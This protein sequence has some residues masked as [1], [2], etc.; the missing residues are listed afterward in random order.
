[1]ILLSQRD[2]RWKNLKLGTG[3][4]TSTIGAFGC[5][6]T[7]LGMILETTPDVVNDRINSVQGYAN[8]NLVI[9]AKLE[10]AFP[11]LKIKRVWTYDNT[12]VKANV[13]NVLVEVDGKPIGGVRHWVIYIGGGKANDPW[14]GKEKLTSSYPDPLSYCVIGGK[15]NKPSPTA[16]TDTQWTQN[17]DNW[18][19]LL[20]R[21]NFS[22]NKDIVFAELDKLP[23][24]EDANRDKDKQLQVKEQELAEIRQKGSDLEKQLEI[25]SQDLSA[26]IS[27][28]TASQITLKEL[29]VQNDKFKREIEELK[30]TPVSPVLKTW[31]YFKLFVNSFFK[32]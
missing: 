23:L 15:W 11:G 32:I 3:D 30:Q 2:P 22:N 16:T 29:E 14:D 1:M 10:Q 12:D 25:A 9:W 13:P 18:L 31:D 4:A 8:G 6:V 26:L 17:S 7:A 24:L 20:Q 5:T 19:A 21:Y 27:N 28:Y